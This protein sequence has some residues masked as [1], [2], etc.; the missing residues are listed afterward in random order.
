MSTVFKR[1]NVELEIKP[2]LYGSAKAAIGEIY[3]GMNVLG[4]SKG[5][6]SLVDL[7]SE[8]ARQVGECDAVFCTW[9]AAKRD[10]SYLYEFVNEHTFRSARWLVDR[11]FTTRQPEMCAH[12]LK[13]YGPENVRITRTH[14]KFIVLRN[15]DWN[16][17]LRTSMNLNKN[18]RLE[19][20]EISD[21]SAMADF[22]V[23]IVD[24]VYDVQQE[25]CWEVGT[26][27]EAQFNN[28]TLVDGEWVVAGSKSKKK[29]R[30]YVQSKEALLL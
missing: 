2:E 20:W 11:S 16:I 15:D 8:L 26:E 24:A 17:C 6:Y 21:S 13:T 1:E 27:H 22:M 10:I 14:A 23:G 25:E 9:T 7:A 5:E 30:G 3:Q 4:F 18:A 19:N 29:K 12:L 28:L